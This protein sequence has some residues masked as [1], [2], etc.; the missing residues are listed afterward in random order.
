[1]SEDGFPLELE[2]GKFKFVKMLSQGGQG[3]VCLYETKQPN[4]ISKSIYPQY[5]AVKFDPSTETANLTETLWLKNL[6]KRIKEEGIKINIPKYYLHSFKDGRRYFVMDYLPES[7]EDL[8]NSRGP[9]GKD[10]MLAEVAVKMLDVL[11]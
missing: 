11:E 9:D 1:M 7:L 6:E 5:V 2:F 4:D 10:E 8:I 3:M